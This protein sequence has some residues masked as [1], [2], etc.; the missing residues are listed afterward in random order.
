MNFKFWNRILG[1]LQVLQA[2]AWKEEFWHWGNLW[3]ECSPSTDTWQSCPIRLACFFSESII[4]KTFHSFFIIKKFFRI[5][6]EIFKHIKWPKVVGWLLG[7]RQFFLRSF[8]NVLVLVFIPKTVIRTKDFHRTR[9]KL[10]VLLEVVNHS[11]PWLSTKEIE[12]QW[13]VKKIR[14]SFPRQTAFANFRRKNF[15]VEDGF[16]LGQALEHFHLWTLSGVRQPHGLHLALGRVLRWNG[17]GKVRSDQ[18]V[19]SFATELY[20]SSGHSLSKTREHLPG[21]GRWEGSLELTALYQLVRSVAFDIA[22]YFYFFT[23][24]SN[25]N[26]EVHCTEPSIS[27]SLPC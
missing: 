3:W 23:K 27:V 25:L 9:G 17:S 10:K 4:L 6:G 18:Q 12:Y 16:G 5:P 8:Q 11:S 13:K 15:S 19:K 20:E 21:R 1:L 26:G 24:T 22:N 2:V 14:E 7:S